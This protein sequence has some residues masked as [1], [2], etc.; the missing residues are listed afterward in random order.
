MAR[1]RVLAWCLSPGMEHSGRALPTPLFTSASLL[2]S[3]DLTL[4]TYA[5]L[6]LLVT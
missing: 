2:V 5:C 6:V 3:M 1:P 4:Y